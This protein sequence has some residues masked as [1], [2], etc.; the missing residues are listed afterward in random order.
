MSALRNKR[1]LLEKLEKSKDSPQAKAEAEMRTA[2]QQGEVAKL[3]KEIERMTAEIA[4]L[5]KSG[6]Q[7][8]AN[9][10]KTK[11][12]TAKVYADAA[13]SMVETDMLDA[14]LGQVQLPAIYGMPGVPEWAQGLAG[15]PPIPGGV[16][17]MGPMMGL[18]PMASV[19]PMGPASGQPA[20]PPPGAPLA[21]PQL[22]I[23]GN[24][25]ELMPQAGPQPAAPQLDIP[26][27]PDGQV[28][29]P[30]MMHAPGFPMPPDPTAMP[31]P[32]PQFSPGP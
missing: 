28:V 27:G 8:A 18:P 3:Q 21:G 29:P 16:P 14:Q 31:L 9:V 2:M 20:A 25:G 26:I 17:N 22:D 15:Q 7:D 12:D 24:F 5:N 10:D 4:K 23:P 1:Q 19:G 11:A 30:E 13:K 6:A 32:G